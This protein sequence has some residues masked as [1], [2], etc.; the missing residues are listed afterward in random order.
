[1]RHMRQTSV[2]VDD[3]FDKSENKC[4]NHQKNWNSQ[5]KFFIWHDQ[6]FSA[7]REIAC[8]HAQGLE[9]NFKR[10]SRLIVK[11]VGQPHFIT[12]KIGGVFYFMA[13]TVK[14]YSLC[15]EK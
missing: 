13:I 3:S 12:L 1:M 8:A 2:Y 10:R 14:I 4:I 5:K 11:K 9:G 7:L 6:N 15:C